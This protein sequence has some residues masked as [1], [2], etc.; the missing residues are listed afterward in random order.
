MDLVQKGFYDGMEIQRWGWWILEQGEPCTR[1]Q[2]IIMYVC[3]TCLKP[4]HLPGSTNK[5]VSLNNKFM[6][7]IN[8]IGMNSI[9]RQDGFVVQTGDPEGPDEGFRDPKTGEIRTWVLCTLWWLSVSHP[10]SHL[11]HACWFS[12]PIEIRVIGDKAPTYDFNLEDLGRV[13]E[14]PVL[15]FNAYGTLA[16]ARN[17]FDNNSASSQ[18]C[19]H[20]GYLRR[21]SAGKSAQC[22]QR[23]DHCRFFSYYENP[24]WL[25]PDPT[26]WMDV[27][28]YLDML[29]RDKISLVWWR[30][31]R[32][33]HACSRSHAYSWFLAFDVWLRL[34]TRLNTLRSLMELKIWRTHSYEDGRWLVRCY[35]FS[36][37]RTFFCLTGT[38]ARISRAGRPQVK[39]QPGFS[40][41]SSPHVGG[42]R[43]LDLK[44][45][46]SLNYSSSSRWLALSMREPD[47][48]KECHVFLS[49]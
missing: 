47:R 33:Y 17:E 23:L 43:N 38:R 26:C 12:V 42:L 6:V 11:C 39:Y 20:L 1:H 35:L 15:P 13:N 46:I 25:L 37:W 16:W 22:D 7:W 8:M 24:S 19:S 9:P 49:W 44:G 36:F 4:F 41:I 31:G 34:G 14:Q 30:W 10:H 18:V 32:I 3:N 21:L 40:G 45:P 28:L 2:N 27:L 29:S 48:T 5:S